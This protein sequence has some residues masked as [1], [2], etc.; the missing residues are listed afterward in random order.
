M[1]VTF[2]MAG[3]RRGVHLCFPLAIGGLAFGIGFG[4][5]ALE[6]GLGGLEAVGM[7]ALVFAG[8]SQMMAM[9]AWTD[10]PALLGLAILAVTINIRHVVMGAALHPWL[11]R[12]PI[13]KSHLALMFMTDANWA[14]AM[15]ERRKG[16]T[17]AAI[18]VGS[19]AVMWVGWVSGTGLGAALGGVIRDPQAFGIDALV[20]AFF[21]LMLPALWTGWR[22]L[23]PWGVAA[24]VALLVGQVAP[25]SWHVVAGGLAG[26]ATGA[27]LEGRARGVVL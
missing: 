4:V 25:G 19:G 18:L 21:A 1:N 17:D 27:W 8:A 5:I 6:S 16:E 20:P 22:T 7:S 13:W 14:M 23:L 26:A 9:G 10:P 15:A 11:H 12:L 2:T 24:A 3:F